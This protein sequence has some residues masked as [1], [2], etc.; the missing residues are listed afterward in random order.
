[1]IWNDIIKVSPLKNEIRFTIHINNVCNFKCSYCI[2]GRQSSDISLSYIQIQGLVKVIEK[3]SKRKTTVHVTITWGEPTIHTDFIKILELFLHIKNIHIQIDTNAFRLWDYSQDFKKMSIHNFKERLYFNISYHYHEYGNRI[4]RFIESIRILKNNWL[5]FWIKFLLPDNE[6]LEDFLGIKEYILKETWVKVGQY[7][8]FLLIDTMWSIS[9]SY[10]QEILDFFYW[11]HL[12]DE[13]KKAVRIN[14]ETKVIEV[15]FENRTK[16]KFWLSE[17]S[18]KWLNKFKWFTC[19][20]VGCNHADIHITPWGEVTFGPCYTLDKIRCSIDELDKILCNWDREI[21]CW[22]DACISGLCLKK[23]K[24]SN[25]EKL[26]KIEKILRDNLKRYI[27]SFR[28]VTIKVSLKS[29]IQ[30]IME[31]EEY[32]VYFFVENIINNRYVFIDGWLGYYFLIKNKNN[33]L[34]DVWKFDA[35]KVH[36]IDNLLRVISKFSNIYKIVLL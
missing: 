17:F 32:F 25:Q 23:E 13:N 18:N 20:Y 5:K 11:S 14:K 33:I 36:T 3:I 26:A 4:P 24:S 21:L 34:I 27:K 30:F 19:T 22:E 8:Y 9:K 35:Q 28:L 10:D 6:K 31:F 29:N 7:D 15:E 12:W 16:K 1:M 2:A